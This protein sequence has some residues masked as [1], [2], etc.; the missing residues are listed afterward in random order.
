MR[1][2]VNLGRVFDTTR[3]QIGYRIMINSRETR[4]CTTMSLIVQ[5]LI[6]PISLPFQLMA[7]RHNGTISSSGC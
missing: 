7:I 4:C 3:Q 6:E 1:A 5:L 2:R